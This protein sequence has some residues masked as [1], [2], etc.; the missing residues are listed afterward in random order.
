[1]SEALRNAIARAAREA[2]LRNQAKAP[3]M[4]LRG[5]APQGSALE[6]AERETAEALRQLYNQRGKAK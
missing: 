1:V 4:P 2:H 3:R 5:V 6:E